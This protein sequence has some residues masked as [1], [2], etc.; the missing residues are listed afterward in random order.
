MSNFWGKPQGKRKVF[1]RPRAWLSGNQFLATHR[2]SVSAI[3]GADAPPVFS[4]GSSFYNQDHWPLR[5]FANFLC[6]WAKEHPHCIPTKADIKK[7][8]TRANEREVHFR[9]IVIAATPKRLPIKTAAALIGGAYHE[10]FHSE[11]TRRRNFKADQ[12]TEMVMKRWAMIDDWAPYAKMLLH[13]DNL[14]EDVRIERNGCRT[15]PGV[16][17]KLAETAEY[18]MD[19]EEKSR[20]EAIREWEEAQEKLKKADSSYEIPEPPPMLRPMAVITGLVRELGKGYLTPRIQ[21]TI[22]MYMEEQPQIASLVTE[23]PFRPLV[24][25]AID[26]GNDQFGSF[27]LAMDAIILLD[28]LSQDPEDGDPVGNE[29]EGDGQG[30]ELNK[31]CPSCG[32]K[33]MSVH[34]KGKKDKAGNVEGKAILTCPSCGHQEEVPFKGKIGDA[35][36]KNKG[37]GQGLDI[38]MDILGHDLADMNPEGE[39]GDGDANQGG[40]AGGWSKAEGDQGKL[41]QEDFDLLSEDIQEGHT[42]L[43]EIGG[44]LEESFQEEK[45]SQQSRDMAGVSETLQQKMKPYLPYTREEDEIE[46]VGPSNQGL[47]QDRRNAQILL[48]SV[49]SEV[50]FLR[51][52]LRTIL[53]AME[54]VDVYH[55]VPHGHDLSD[56]FLVDTYMDIQEGLYPTQPFYEEDDHLDVSIAAAIVLDQSGSMSSILRDASRIMM[57]LAEPLDAVGAAI[58]VS[59]FGDGNRHSQHHGSSNEDMS[60]YHRSYAIKHD[61]YMAFGERFGSIMHRFANTRAWGGTPMADGLQLGLEGLEDRK[62]GHRLLFMITDGCPNGG[63]EPVIKYQLEV[64]AKS[65]IHVIGVGIGEYARYVKDLFPDHVWSADIPTFPYALVRKLN[66]LLDFRAIGRGRRL[67]DNA[68]LRHQ[69]KKF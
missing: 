4:R 59:G 12:V 8:V 54:Q 58:Q 67:Q 64:A 45:D 7:L 27:R 32:H 47:E 31:E 44:A 46:F 41:T 17:R 3:L 50:C 9:Q 69:R 39:D 6:E 10:A 43:K 57:A 48:D 53:L 40:G 35:Q 20:M 51:A 38:T 52:R 14:F 36:G 24:K 65:G 30:G 55:G 60:V 2:A 23:G 1:V 11:Q 26:L 68:L 33:P 49:K 15:Y 62:E 18:V 22:E 19:L 5:R 37:N 42:G 21:R 56:Q 29:E 66:E 16:R 25:E 63:H 61:I 28:Q 13:L 34:L